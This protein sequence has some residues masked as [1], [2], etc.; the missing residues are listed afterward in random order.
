MFLR[1]GNAGWS[2]TVNVNILSRNGCVLE[3]GHLPDDITIKANGSLKTYKLFGV[4]YGN[5]N[6]F[7]S[8]MC[9]P[10]PLVPQAGWYEYDALCEHGQRGSGLHYC[11]IAKKPAT[12]F[13]SCLSFALYLRQ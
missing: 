13:A 9:L 6:H 12:P 11:G 5:R 10:S 7:R 8:G 4:T 2:S 1:L 3:V